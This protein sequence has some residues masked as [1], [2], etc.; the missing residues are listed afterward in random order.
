MLTQTSTQFQHFEFNELLPGLVICESSRDLHGWDNATAN[1]PAFLVYL[2]Y[3]VPTERDEWITKL[4]LVWKIEGEIL[5]RP[6][7]RV[8]GYWHEI[9]I[10][11][12]KR[13]SD[14]D[15]FELD[16]LSESQDYGLDFLTQLWQMKLELAVY[17]DAID[18]R[19]L[20]S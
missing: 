1:T 11:G 9:K 8:K 13:Y 14:P 10:R 4:R 6:S 7:Q 15:V 18:T 16:Y 12:M 19:L 20:N 5:D 17:E 2:G 3:N